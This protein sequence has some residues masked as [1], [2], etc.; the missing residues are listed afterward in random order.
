MKSIFV[1]VAIIAVVMSGG[2]NIN[3]PWGGGSIN[4]KRQ[5]EAEHLS[6]GSWLGCAGAIVGTGLTCS[7]GEVATFG[8]ATAACVGGG[9]GAGAACANAFGIMMD[10]DIPLIHG[11]Y[12]LELFPLL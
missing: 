8:A 7:V 4:W 3:T 1:V 10:E 9:L 6:L 5:A 2:V 12:L 11:N